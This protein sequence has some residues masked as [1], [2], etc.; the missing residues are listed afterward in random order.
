MDEF[1]EDELELL[2]LISSLKPYDVMQIAV[3]QNGSRMSVIIKNNAQTFREFK[4]S[5]R[6]ISGL[7]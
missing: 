7:T 1:N 6:S 4:L 5:Q 3:N 2:K